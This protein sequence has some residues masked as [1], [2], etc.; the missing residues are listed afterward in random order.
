[1]FCSSVTAGVVVL[2]NGP[3]TVGED[4]GGTDP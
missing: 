2:E 3:Q 1:L 4:V